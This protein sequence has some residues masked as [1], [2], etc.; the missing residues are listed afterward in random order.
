MF[1]ARPN[2]KCLQYKNPFSYFGLWHLTYTCST[3]KVPINVTT[4]R[5]D[6]VHNKSY[7]AGH[8]HENFTHDWIDT[9]KTLQNLKLL[10]LLLS[11]CPMW[12]FHSSIHS[13]CEYACLFLDE[14]REMRNLKTRNFSQ[15]K[16]TRKTK[17]WES[18]NQ[19][20]WKLLGKK[21]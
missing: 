10:F 1:I 15:G 14:K 11:T 13:D 5:A 3:Y 20:F 21:W 2:A 12:Q 8:F 17:K 16:Q 4:F 6:V 18:K 9:N 7:R 19:A